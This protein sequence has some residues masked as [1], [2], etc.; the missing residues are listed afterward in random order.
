MCHTHAA[1][2]PVQMY[3]TQLAAK[4]L[5][6]GMVHSDER[7]KL[8]SDVI[9]GI[10][11]VKTQA[12]EPFF[13]RRVTAARA[14]ELAVLWESFKLAALNTLILQTVPTVVTI[15]TFSVYVLLGNELTATKAFTAMSL[16][17][18]LRFPLFQLPMV[19]S[20]V[21]RTQVA[22]S[23]LHVRTSSRAPC[24]F[25]ASLLMSPCQLA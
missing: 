16:F 17:S 2:A 24:F 25:L 10:E 8:E 9:T 11:A 7:T 18:V 13:L 5:N 14:D 3:V 19:M 21:T 1:V 6:R 22:F 4:I 15:A 12:W 20:Q 23:R